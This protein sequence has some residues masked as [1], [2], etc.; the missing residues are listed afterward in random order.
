MHVNNLLKCTTFSNRPCRLRMTKSV[1]IADAAMMQN[2]DFTM[3]LIIA[4]VERIHMRRHSIDHVVVPVKMQSPQTGV[5][6]GELM[7]VD[8]NHCLT[9]QP[10]MVT[11]TNIRQY[12][13]FVGM[14]VI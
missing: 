10:M 12:I 4:D 2:M 6:M 9:D 1:K 5:G 11:T 8:E 14:T 3:E 7:F 13:L